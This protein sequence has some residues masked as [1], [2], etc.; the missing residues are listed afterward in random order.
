M[1]R[2]FIAWFGPDIRPSGSRDWLLGLILVFAVIAAYQSAWN[3]GFIW[4]DDVYVTGNPLLWAPDGLRRIWLSFESPSQYFPLTYT[5]FRLEYALWGLNS[6]G[7]HSVNILLHATN[8]L[9]V[10]RLL[11]KLELPGAWLGAAIWALHPV[12]VESVAWV[13]ELKNLLMCFFFLLTL[14]V[15]IWFVAQ[16]SGWRWA[17]YALALTFYALALFSKTTAC[18]LPAA[19]FLI[20]W[21]K[22]RPINRQRIAQIIP[23]L[24]L[25][26]GMGLLTMWWE[27]YHMGTRGEV[28]AM[29]LLDRTLLASRAVWFYV[30]KLFW[31]SNLMFSYPRWNISAFD[32]RDYVWLAATLGCGLAI[33]YTRRY[34]GR[35]VEVAALFFATTLSPVLGF[36]MLYTF[37]YSFVAD[38]YQYVASIGLVT[39]VSAGIARAI[40]SFEVRGRWL[41]M[42]LCVSVLVLLGTLSWRQARVY[43][44]AETLWADTVRKNPDSWLGR[45]NLG[46]ALSRAGNMDEAIEQYQKVLQIKPDYAQ[47]HFN[48]ANALVQ[49]G[50]LDEAIAHFHRALQI[51]PDYLKAESNLALLLATSPQA[52]LRNG[53]QAMKLAQRANQRAGGDNIITLRVL[54]AAYAE[55]GRFGDAVRSA[56]KADELARAAGQSD[57]VAMLDSELR[58]YRAG[59]PFHQKR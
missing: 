7:Y 16:E 44:S 45:N 37:Y 58:L 29:G 22:D 13:T 10:W 26:V 23:F 56:Q 31:P 30:A 2:D 12:Q 11:R 17:G 34:V 28:F 42:T 19:L 57:L 40:A 47:A 8:A 55:G 27:R 18:T 36:I 54:A 4:D 48:L 43:L 46:N 1:R 20:L 21:L 3:A 51:D 6:T 41:A 25:G 14:R 15:W 5:V 35:G 39:L 59:L 49:S 24:V 38:H 53:Q 32:P 33:I 50:R 52:W 9:L